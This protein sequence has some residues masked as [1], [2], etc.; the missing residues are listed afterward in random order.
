MVIACGWNLDAYYAVSVVLLMHGRSCQ[1]SF[2]VVVKNY[3]KYKF[4]KCNRG[5]GHA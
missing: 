1:A 5:Y 2:M 3:Y 4:F